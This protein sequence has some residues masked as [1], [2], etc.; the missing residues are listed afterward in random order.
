MLV[1]AFGQT[2]SLEDPDVK[3]VQYVK[4]DRPAPPKA[5]VLVRPGRELSKEVGSY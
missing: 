4:H 5:I 2:L 3:C 1:Q